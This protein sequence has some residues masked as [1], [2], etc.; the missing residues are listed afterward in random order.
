[1][2]YLIIA[3]ATLR[4]RLTNN[5]LS[6]CNFRTALIR[7]TL[8]SA[9]L[10]LA[11][12]N[13]APQ[14]LEPNAEKPQPLAGY[15]LDNDMSR[16][17]F[18]SVKKSAI[19][20]NHH[21]LSVTGA[22]DKSGSA[23]ISVA[24]D[25]VETLIPIRNERMRKYLF[26]IEKYPTAEINAAVD[27]AAL[28]DLRAG[29]YWQG[30]IDLTLSLHGPQKAYSAQVDVIRLAAGQLQVST[31]QPLLIAADDFDLTGGIAML[32]K[33]ANLPSIAQTVPVNVRLVFALEQ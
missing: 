9:C 1:M 25:S 33:L 15:V 14:L 23:N 22:V 10:F 20:E 32:A 4:E 16:I 17:S 5:L 2:C 24:L 18:L 7:L 6:I 31:P 8:V 12:C 29:E 3:A 19:V 26:E 30:A 11:A 28:H 13:K 21:F 27:I